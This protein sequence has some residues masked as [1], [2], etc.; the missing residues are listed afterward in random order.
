[1]FEI[2]SRLHALV[3]LWASIACLGPCGVAQAETNQA[4]HNDA[5]VDPR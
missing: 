1:M 4:D 3:V 2:S 5:L